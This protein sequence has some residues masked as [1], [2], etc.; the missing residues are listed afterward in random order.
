[1][2]LANVFI[3]RINNKYVITGYLNNKQIDKGPYASYSEALRMLSKSLEREAI[4]DETA[5]SRSFS[6]D[7]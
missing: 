3:D 7:F 1:M 2:T 4:E 6:R 5:S